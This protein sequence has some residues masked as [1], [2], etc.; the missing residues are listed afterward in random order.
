MLPG[1]GT[2]LKSVKRYPFSQHLC[3]FSGCIRDFDLNT[4]IDPAAMDPRCYLFLLLMSSFFL[5]FSVRKAS[6]QSL[7]KVSIR[8][9]RSLFNNH[10]TVC[11]CCRL[12][13]LI[14]TL[15]L[16]VIFSYNVN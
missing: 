2:Q 13:M 14:L 16:T 8:N 5:E 6:A 4:K 7:V 9:Q 15:F 12:C 11:C 3:S 10:T 1:L